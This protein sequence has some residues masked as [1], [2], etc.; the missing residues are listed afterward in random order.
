MKR[1]AFPILICLFATLTVMLLWVR[2]ASNTI[3]HSSVVTSLSSLMAPTLKP[4]S[5]G[6]PQSG[7]PIGQIAA[8]RRKESVAKV[9]SALSTPIT[10]YGK[11]VDQNGNPVA[12]ADVDYGTIDKF[13]ANGSD[14]TGKSDGN[15]SFF[16]SGIAGAVLTVGVRKEGYYNIHG[17]SDAAFAYGVAP[18]A[19][20][21]E[22]P[23]ADNPAIFVLQ[24]MG[25]TEPLMH[26]NSRQYKV[27]K[28][29]EPMEINLLTGKQVSLGQGSIRF[30]RR[31]ND[32]KKDQH[33][34][35]DWSVRVTIPNGGLVE[36]EGQFAFEA[37]ATGYEPA[38]EINMPAE[39]GE[40]WRYSVNKDYFVRIR[41]GQYARV[42]LEIYAGHDNSIV[43]ESFVNPNPG[44]RNLEFDPKKAIKAP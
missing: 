24:K 16:K 34:R 25:A 10:F 13:D 32:E 40:Q 15:G 33:G 38:V 18:D 1:W 12:D 39:L 31:A 11:V 21:K 7:S 6:G 22:P 8:A 14:Y 5:P 3:N 17:A 37:P 2:H 26:V 36:R 42:N 29:G 27:S 43:L 4:T 44:S 30:E 23:T 41:E 35:F 19:T 20:R 28:T 9:I